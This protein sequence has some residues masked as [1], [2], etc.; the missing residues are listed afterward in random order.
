[1]ILESHS[2]NT[3]ENLLF[4][5]AIV[6]P[7]PGEVWLLATSAMHM[8]RAMAIARKLD[9]RMTPWPTDFITGPGSGREIWQVADNL[10]LLDYVVHEWLGLAAYRL[11]GKAR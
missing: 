7:K 8:P 1:M 4:S 9:W 11:T 2:R 10:S 3:Y 5:K 6:E